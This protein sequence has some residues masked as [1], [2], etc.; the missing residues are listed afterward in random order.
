M[1]LFSAVL[2]L[3]L[4]SVD[5]KHTSPSLVPCSSLMMLWVETYIFI[6]P[7]SLLHKWAVCSL[8]FLPGKNLLQSGLQFSLSLSADG[9]WHLL[10]AYCNN[11]Y[12][13]GH[14]GPK[15]KMLYMRQLR[16]RPEWHHRTL[17]R[18]DSHLGVHGSQPPGICHESSPYPSCL[19]DAC[20]HHKPA[21]RFPSKP[22]VTC[23]D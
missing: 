17:A 11:H 21:P 13:A 10:N 8:A 15:S 22:S 14:F 7:R 4:Y 18:V 19:W 6:V 23:R 3:L 20:T 1:Q 16:L 12:R 2:L 5:W 9:G